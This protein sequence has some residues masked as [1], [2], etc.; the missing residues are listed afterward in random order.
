VTVNASPLRW[1]FDNLA[2]PPSLG[3]GIQKTGIAL[4]LDDNKQKELIKRAKR[5]KHEQDA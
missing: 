2:K 4:K 3:G 1:R 5:Q